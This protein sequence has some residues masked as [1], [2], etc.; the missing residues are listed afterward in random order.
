MVSTTAASAATFTLLS[1]HTA[2]ASPWHLMGYW[3]VGVPETTSA[4]ALTVLLFAAPLYERL[5]IDG[6]WEEWVRLQP[7]TAVWNQWP[8]WRN[9]VAVSC[10]VL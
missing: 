7:L 6:A 5:F 4:L 1:L 3:P 2:A 8:S 9:L 10:T